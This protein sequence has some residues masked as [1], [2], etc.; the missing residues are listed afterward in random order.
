MPE[1]P[2]PVPADSAD[3][4]PS[5]VT[6][7]RIIRN[8]L[9]NGMANASSAIVT[10]ALTPFLL[11]R[12][13][14]EQYG[15]WLLALSLT[16]SGGYLALADLGLSDAGVRFIAEARATGAS[17]TINE[18]VS[19]MA[20]VFAVVG[21]VAAFVLG[22][23][24]PLVVRLF[25]VSD[26]LAQAATQVFVLIALGLILELPTSALLAV[27]QGA[28]RYLWLRTIDTGGR[29]AWAAAVVT[30]VF[31]GH[32]VV[33]LAALSLTLSAVK[34]AGAFWVA[35]RVQPGLHV[36]PGF[37]SRATLR[38]TL[39]YG[40][41][42]TLLRLLSVVYTQMDRAIIGIALTVAAIANYEVAFRIESVAT[43]VRVTAAS[44]LLPAAA[45]SAAR[46]DPGK[47]RQLYLRGTAYTVGL[48]APVVLA[49]MIYARPLIR[50]WVGEGYVHMAGPARL[51]LICSLLWSFQQVGVTMF[52]GLGL[53]RRILLLQ[54]VSVVLNLAASLSF[55]HSLGISGVILGTVIGAAVVQV[56]YTWLFI[57]Y[58]RISLGSWLRRVVIPNI[59][60]PLAQAAVGLLTLRWVN[61]L[62]DLWAVALICVGSCALSLGIFAMVGLQPEERSKVLSQLRSG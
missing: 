31:M 21:F 18:V 5:E 61:G 14:T 59:P 35:H 34:A 26:Q 57:S 6:G 36:R 28:Q 43:L 7:G 53:V 40:S 2:A 45:Y 3:L 29:L 49:A 46:G 60:G 39:A 1:E 48:V 33:A 23:L 4:P 44:A 10:I 9:V 15:V 8:T 30:A 52:L 25:D 12:L 58:F 11:H 17:G 54:V 50:A 37:A 47:Q 27:I 56:P 41:G 62:D 22:V 19:T 32:G 13:G 55:V 51:F 42:L 16:F 24:A 20:V 38:R